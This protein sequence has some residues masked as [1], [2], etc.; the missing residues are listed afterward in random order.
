MHE[1]CGFPRLI[2]RSKP[3]VRELFRVLFLSRRVQ[4]NRLHEHVRRRRPRVGP[5]PLLSALDE[6]RSDPLGGDELG[7]SQSLHHL[8]R[9]FASGVQGSAPERGEVAHVRSLAREDELA[10]VTNDGAGVLADEG[11]EGDVSPAL[12]VVV[13]EHGIDGTSTHLARAGKFLQEM[14]QGFCLS[15]PLMW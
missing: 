13:P 15:L 11:L 1:P 14:V 7:C 12:G 6:R 2:R 8:V 4:L 5:I 3:R 9:A 10:D